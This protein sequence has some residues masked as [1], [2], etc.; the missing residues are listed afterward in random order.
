MRTRFLAPL[1]ALAVLAL[2]GTACSSSASSASERPV[3]RLASIASSG[4]SASAYGVNVQRGVKLAVELLGEGRVELRSWDD[5]STN[6]GGTAA[7]RSALE[8][9]A[10]VVLMPTLSPVALA[11]AP[12]GTAAR[13]PML[14]VSNATIDL[15]DAGDWFWR[16]SKSETQMVTASVDAVATRG[17]T[18]VLLWEPA[19]GYSQ[20]SR[21]AFVAAA[22]ERGVTI[23]SELAYV[24]GSTTP[25]SLAA[26]A[27]SSSPDL[28]FMALRSG[29]AAD[30]LTATA[31]TSAVRVGGNGFN[32]MPVI[33]KAGSAADGL[34][35]AGSWNRDEPV[36]M[37]Q[38]F[39]DRY[40]AA[41][42]SV[43][44]SFAAQGYGAVQVVLAA[45]RNARTISPAGL[46]A[47]L[48]ALGRTTNDVATVLGP[49]GFTAE[50]EP[51]YAAVVQQVRT[52]NL[53]PYR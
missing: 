10:T 2:I 5:L 45:A 1:A 4:G 38:L 31:G 17:Q 36:A 26:R 47:G 8:W 44:D 53:V 20:G 15:A 41:Y 39:I 34:I 7:M 22:A 51:T 19:D 50:R 23:T 25:A 18:A 21:A 30:F 13:T 33:S 24:D 37:S 6:D 35:V 11:A 3:L 48:A 52:G 12:L 9:D 28:L 14:G 43:P 32:A 40:T 27:A 46:Q 16:I 42:G 29:V 49:F